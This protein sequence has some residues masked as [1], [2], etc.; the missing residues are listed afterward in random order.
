MYSLE[1]GIHLEPGFLVHV[2]SILFRPL[3]RIFKSGVSNVGSWSWEIWLFPRGRK[4]NS[5][6]QKLVWRS[7]WFTKAELSERMVVID[8]NKLCLWI[9]VPSDTQERKSQRI[10]LCHYLALPQIKLFTLK[11]SRLKSKELSIFP[12]LIAWAIFHTN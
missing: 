1:K 11:I 5:K 8:W 12:T 4:L 3:E 7:F 6:T 9:W 2:Y 10:L